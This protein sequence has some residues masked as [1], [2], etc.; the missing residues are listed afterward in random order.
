MVNSL[1][2]LASHLVM[3]LSSGLRPL[4]GEHLIL[5]CACIIL[6][7]ADQRLDCSRL[8]LVLV[9]LIVEQ[10]LRHLLL[11]LGLAHVL[12]DVVVVRLL[13]VHDLR[14]LLLPL[15]LVEQGDLHFFVEFHLLAHLLLCLLLHVAS[16]LVD[17]V[18]RLLPRLLDLLE[19][20]IL[21]RFQ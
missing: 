14:L 9:V 6:L 8:S 1:G 20:T 2:L 3:H 15:G 16:A 21:F 13:I 10:V 12:P 11:L 4:L 17:D 18:S 19:S 5:V 7:L